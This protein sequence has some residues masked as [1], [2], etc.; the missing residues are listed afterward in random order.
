MLTIEEANGIVRLVYGRPDR[1]FAFPDRGDFLSRKNNFLID[2]IIKPLGDASYEFSPFTSFYVPKENGQH[3]TVYQSATLKDE[4][5]LIY[6]HRYLLTKTGPMLPDYVIGYRKKKDNPT[7][8][9]G[10]I[11]SAMAFSKGQLGEWVIKT[12]IKNYYESIDKTRMLAVINSTRKEYYLEA[13]IIQIIKLLVGFSGPGL[14]TG[15]S[16]V[17]DLANLYL[18]PFDQQIQRKA[19]KYYR[20]GDDI[21]LF[22]KGPADKILGSID[23]NLRDY[24]LSLSFKKT[25]LLYPGDSFEYIGFSFKNGE[26]SLKKATVKRIKRKA[27]KIMN[28]P[29]YRKLTLGC[30]NNNR[31]LF[32][33]FFYEITGLMAD[34]PIK[35]RMRYFILIGNDRPYRQIDK[36]LISHIRRKI[37]GTWSE[38]GIRQMP[39][40]IF[41]SFGFISSCCLF[42]KMERAYR[43][44]GKL[45]DRLFS[46]KGLEQAFLHYFKPSRL[47]NEWKEYFVNRKENSLNLLESIKSNRFEFADIRLNNGSRKPI[48]A[49]G[50]NEKIILRLT[51]LYLKKIYYPQLGPASTG[52]YFKIGSAVRLMR[53]FHYRQKEYRL[54]RVDLDQVHERLDRRIIW[55]ILKDMPISYGIE[56]IIGSFFDRL[57]ALGIAGLP[58]GTPINNIL[59]EAYLS[60][61][62]SYLKPKSPMFVRTVDDFLIICDSKND[63]FLSQFELYLKKLNMVSGENRFY[64]ADNRGN[65]IVEYLGYLFKK[66]SGRPLLITIDGYNLD[67]FKNKIVKLTKKN[68]DRSLR[69]IVGGINRLICA[70]SRQYSFIRYYARTNDFHLVS[71]LD[72]YI[73]DRIRIAFF[74]RCR[75]KD[76]RRL[77]NCDLHNN[78]GLVNLIEVLVKAKK[79][80][81]RKRVLGYIGDTDPRSAPKAR[82]L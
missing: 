41:H 40:S 30:L 76:R 52:V 70:P 16:P 49:H 44:R 56:K 43:L 79:I 68:R 20:Y 31:Y 75:L 25:K 81:A 21:I 2:K 46:T 12:D 36:W 17:N 67:K 61:V 63:N 23:E 82:A 5:I 57:T 51:H 4:I 34:S 53:L 9:L 64:A 15:L 54:L 66:E 33:L 10:A 38:K 73:C 72:D 74:K 11:R 47:M 35:S 1:F 42:H 62:D 18:L 80:I 32:S 48:L 37:T 22:G 14:P 60:L 27:M 65:F 3:R 55:S 29:A 7:G 6:L 39:Y 45:F 71:E 59:I 28:R 58:R 13:N 78:Y 77:A 26:A 19:V 8:V 24:G 69:Q 50:I